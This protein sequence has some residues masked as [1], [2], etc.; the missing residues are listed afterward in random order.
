MSAIEG[1]Y[2]IH[3]S[4]GPEGFDHPDLPALTLANATLNAA[5]SYL[6]K[7]IRGSGLAY[8]ANVELD[9]ESGLMGFSIYRVGP[10]RG[11][12]DG[13]KET[14]EIEPKRFLGLS[15]RRKDPQGISGW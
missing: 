12:G 6:W 14:D 11:F 10:R 13:R 5:E 8:G 7:S 1:S 3:Y 4:K 9:V 2:G 15:G